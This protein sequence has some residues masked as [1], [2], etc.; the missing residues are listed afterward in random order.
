MRVWV[1]LCVWLMHLCVGGYERKIRM[2]QNMGTRLK[3]M[4]V[5]VVNRERGGEEK[6]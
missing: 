5:C 4:R 2:Y 6:S 3:R 1:V